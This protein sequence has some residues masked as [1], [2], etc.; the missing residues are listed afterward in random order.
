MFKV[1]QL[2]SG[3]IRFVLRS[4]STLCK[5]PIT[6]FP[7]IFL[8]FCFTKFNLLKRGVAAAVAACRLISKICRR[9]QSVGWS[10]WV[11]GLPWRAGLVLL[12]S[13]RWQAGTIQCFPS[14]LVRKQLKW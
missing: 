12:C 10:T 5:S 1:T 3:Q 2:I 4:D 9:E 13:S 6:S 11:T 8:V 14:S 7:E